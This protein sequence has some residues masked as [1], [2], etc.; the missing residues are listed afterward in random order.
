MEEVRVWVAPSFSAVTDNFVDFIPAGCSIAGTYTPHCW[1][2]WYIQNFDFR[3][4]L[5]ER[6]TSR[7]S[8]CVI[9][10]T[11]VKIVQ[12]LKFFKLQFQ[13]RI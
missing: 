3:V 1:H 5:R 2:C 6:K 4:E 9:S 7:I 8:L 11:E 10:K 13:G 12:K